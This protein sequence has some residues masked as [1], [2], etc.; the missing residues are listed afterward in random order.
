MC[1]H[2]IEV[3]LPIWIQRN[4]D[5]TEYK[6]LVVDSCLAEITTKLLSA[7]IR[8]YGSCCGHFE[9]CGGFIIDDHSVYRA[10]KNG[11]NISVQ[12]MVDFNGREFP[13]YHLNLLNNCKNCRANIDPICS[14]NCSCHVKG[15]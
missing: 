9:S 14:C 5:H 2:G 3:E 6:P 11:H 7:G 15:E 13:I 4:N 10:I 12:W 1:K 8:T